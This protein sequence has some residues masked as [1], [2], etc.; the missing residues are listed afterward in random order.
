MVKLLQTSLSEAQVESLTSEFAL[1]KKQSEALD[2]RMNEIKKSLGEYVELMGE[3][4][5]SGH[6][7]LEFENPVGGYKALVRQRRVKR[8]LDEEA[9]ESIL[10]NAG[11][12]NE[13]YV[14]VPTLDEQAVFNA[15]N[16][17]LITDSDIEKI[18]PSKV[19]YAFAPE[20]A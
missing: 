18:Y 12:K 16:R 3:K 6:F 1:L 14:L 5:T 7:R 11:L 20:K 13:C 4:D 19:S 10:T 17:G 9:A 8:T 15:L 2:T